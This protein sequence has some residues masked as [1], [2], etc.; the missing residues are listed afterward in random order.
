MWALHEGS[1]EAARFPQ[2]SPDETVG[3]CVSAHTATGPLAPADDRTADAWIAVVVRDHH[4]APA[5]GELVEI[6]LDGGELLRARTDG[7]G[8]VRFTGLRPDAGRAVCSELLEDV[9]TA[10]GRPEEAAP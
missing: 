6:A 2:A 8:R 5:R 3:G 1:L 4:G 7:D 9:E 10:S